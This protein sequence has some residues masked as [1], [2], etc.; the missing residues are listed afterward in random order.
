MPNHHA[1]TRPQMPTAKDQARS[2]HQKT[3]LDIMT[4][5]WDEAL[6]DWVQE[7]ISEER[8]KNWGIL[9]TSANP[10]ADM[11]RQL[12]TPGLYGARPETRHSEP[13]AVAILI[14]QDQNLD[15]AGFWTK[16]QNVQF[17]TIGMGD[18]VIRLDAPESVGHLTERPVAPHNVYAVGPQ[19]QP[20]VPH[21]LWELRVRWWAEQKKHLYTW[22]V[23]DISDPKNPEY[24]VCEANIDGSCGADISNV[25]LNGDFTG[26]AYP[27][28]YADGSPFIPY[29]FYR[30]VDTGLMWNQFQKRGVHRGTLNAAMYWSYAA[31]CA[32]ACTGNFVIVAGLSPISGAKVLRDDFA[33]DGGSQS[34]HDGTEG[35]LGLEITPGSIAYHSHD[36]SGNQPF[37][38]E[39]GAGVNLPEVSAFANEYEMKLAVRFGLN[40][41]DV[42]RQSANP[43]SGA[44]LFISN[45]GRRTFANQ[46]RPLFR[47]A[48]MESLRKSAALLNLSTFDDTGDIPE[49]GYSITY[50]PIPRSPQEDK[51]RRD[52]LTWQV[53]EGYISK[54]GGYMRLHQGATVDDA[55]KALV[56]I[57]VEELRL[58]QEFETAVVAA[59]LQVAATDEE[60][61][62]GAISATDKI[63]VS[64]FAGAYPDT[65]GRAILEIMV[66]VSGDEAMRLLPLNTKPKPQPTTNPPTTDTTPQE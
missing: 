10:L 39:I 3:R 14:G 41:S 18:F 35:I 2:I 32:Q 24:K 44:A 61:R 6:K 58:K 8:L 4:D 28:R 12:S 25:F 53:D 23:F 30:A 34:F 66:G 49:T 46:V 21:I 33:S 11:S 64:V 1:L 59:G 55:R 51:E 17:L 19:N 37:V 20:D 36:G 60:E 65:V 45:S 57:Q 56:E 54:V 50:A 7:S 42:T 38:K 52:S 62:I 26:D 5:D 40:P 27:F 22:D 47:R 31:Y 9:D 15:K 16:S 63:I 48:D 29:V 43:T 13:E